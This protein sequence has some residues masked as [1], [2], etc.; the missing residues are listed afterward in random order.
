[1]IKVIGVGG[2]GGAA[3]ECMIRN[4]MCGVECI[5]ADTDVAALDARMAHTHLQLGQTGLNSGLQPLA[6]SNAAI[7]AREMIARSLH[8]AHL[9]LIVAGMGGGT[10]TGA[11]PTIARIARELGIFTVAVVTTPFGFEGKRVKLAEAGITALK[12]HVDSLILIDGD[13]VLSLLDDEASIDKAFDAARNLQEIAVGDI[14]GIMN[15]SGFASVAFQDVRAVMCQ[16]GAAMIGSAKA[17][18]GNRAYMAAERA[19]TKSLLR[20]IDLSHAS[21]VL[22][23]ITADRKLTIDEVDNAMKMIRRFAGDHVFIVLGAI[24]DDSMGEYL[25]V[26]IIATGLWADQPSFEVIMDGPFGNW[27]DE[28]SATPNRSPD[29][30]LVS[31]EPEQETTPS[32]APTIATTKCPIYYTKHYRPDDM[33]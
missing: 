21:G 22:V 3:V 2:A 1:M 29:L 11:T 16:P 28:C 19:L 32:A 12:E 26:T 23:S 9:I 27:S 13:K 6:G 24:F 5:V 8:G 14:A 30:C 25:R 20:V 7:Q 17:S 15:K 4:G 31:S 10:G 18:G 33:E